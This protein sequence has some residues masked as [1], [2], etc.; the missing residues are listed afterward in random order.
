MWF[1]RLCIERPVLVVMIEALL[2]VLGFIGYRSIGVDLYPKIDPPVITVTTLYPGAGPE[3]VETLIS[4]KIEEEVNQIGGTKRIVSTSQQGI[5]RV[6]VEFELEVNAQTAQ[7]EVRDKLL[8]VRGDL[9]TEIEEPL[10]ERLDFGDRP[11]ITL[12]LSGQEGPDSQAY[13]GALLRLIADE[14][15]KPQLQK[16]AGVGQIHLFGGDE[17]EVQVLVDRIRLQS[18]NL[19]LPE[20]TEA[21]RRA[22]VNTPSGEVNEYPARRS[23]RV[24][25]EF[26]KP[27][28]I[29]EVIIKTLP[30]G[31]VVRV[32]DVAKIIDGL[33]ERTTL[34]RF[35]GKPV[36]LLEIKKQS[37]A[38]TVEVAERTLNQLNKAASALPS[39]LKLESVYDASK[40]IRMSVHD[41]IET[42]VI[43]AILAVV[44]VYCFLGSLQSTLITGLAL[45]C[46][47][48]ASF[49]V[50]NAQ[51]FTLNMMTLLGLTLSVGLILDDAIVIRENIWNK[52]EQGMAAK[53]AAFEGT[54][55]VMVAV[56]ATSLT[57]LA[58][59][60]PVAFISG[61]VGRFLA[62]FALTVCIGIV[63]STFDAVTMAPMLSANLMRHK[64]GEAHPAKRGFLLERLEHFGGTVANGYGRLLNWCLRHPKTTIASSAGMLV[65]S[66]YL[67][68]Y[69]GFTFL[70]DNEAGEIQITLEAVP[71]T[72]FEKMQ[73]MALSA[74]GV[75]VGQVPELER[76]STR[77]GNEN[78]ETNY[79]SI[80]L[81]M[82]HY[83]ERDRSTA[84]VKNAL[85]YA[86]RPFAESQ[87]ITL[88]IGNPGGGGQG[89]PLTMVVQGPDN[90][91]LQ[92]L[93]ADVMR[94][95]QEKVPGVT[96]LD[97]N[98]KP[99]RQELQLEIDR[100][101]AAAFGLRV[102]DIGDNVRGMYEGLLAGVFRESG[103][104]YD[105]R[106][107]LRDE[108]RGDV[109]SLE[110]LT[111]P[112]DRGDAVPLR[113]VATQRLDT[114]P[115]SIVRIDLR[116]SARI[117]GDLIPGAALGTVI[118]DVRQVV[119][120]LIPAGYTFNFQGQA[121]SLADLRMG[122][123]VALGLGALFIYMVMASLYESF[124]MP[125]A[126]LM[127][128]PLALIG[129]ILGLLVSGKLLDIYGVIGVILLMALVT[130][131]AILLIDY[132]EQ[133]KRDG[134]STYD[135]IMQAGLRRMRPIVMT[136][137]AMIA[138]MLPVAIGYGELNKV[139]AGMGIA[140]IGGLISSTA[141]S[142]LVVPC[143]YVYLDRFRIVSQSLIDR[144]Y[145]RRLVNAGR[146]HQ[147][148]SHR[149]SPSPFSPQAAPV[150]NAVMEREQQ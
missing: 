5:S 77:V 112:N 10:I 34:A 104:E 96:N 105:I 85:R 12:A 59:F 41:V 103:E 90:K 129:A 75:A 120:P 73:E 150:V 111:L 94:A 56:I 2:L 50:L 76:Y 143:V 138:G 91:V 18:Y 113:A 57:V 16:V 54:R 99:G 72:S 92:S 40:L 15:V 102:K 148:E 141:L 19:G 127:T 53:Q 26:A 62:A 145:F 63:L 31:Q 36:V 8:R 89:K 74:E 137:I 119:Q 142:L 93:A 3:E 146:K 117:D 17:R 37:D 27:D 65:L 24:L 95:I 49:F 23:V 70:P 114:S 101:N 108:Q 55:E 7:N 118:E 21:I 42:I 44:V 28:E 88:G 97:S 69:V 71:G 13:S 43:A 9:P 83:S 29:A 30:G 126:I 1:I 38:N 35:N 33:K 100:Q 124:V 22:N 115:T 51:G 25:G 4:K 149:T 86:L 79:A 46:T 134:M 78:G 32:G 58:V 132:A 45:P 11:V 147:D 87:K 116:R 60:F 81:N 98:L 130:K 122:A 61:I 123:L 47:I 107:R 109:L 68:K 136:S 20:I 80:F 110:N 121:E 82:V 133:L 135:A 39:G 64:P 106:V 140:S 128:L 66:I 125:F 144:W 6:T 139:R 52:I 131:N 67:L 48:I 14:Q 84:E